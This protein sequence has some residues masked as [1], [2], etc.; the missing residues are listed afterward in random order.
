[1]GIFRNVSG[2]FM[3]LCNPGM[4]ATY[5][6]MVYL[7]PG[8]IQNPEHI[9]NSVK[10]LQSS[11]LRKI[12][13]GCN[14]FRNA[15]FSRSL[16]YEINIMNIYFF[17]HRHKKIYRCLNFCKLLRNFL[18]TFQQNICG[19]LLCK[20]TCR[21]SRKFSIKLFRAGIKF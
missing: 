21:P 12:V 13:N 3:A 7:E 6:F 8:H 14:Y 20:Y 19:R 16:L 11:V 4:L 9:Q 1:M 15:N 17:F 18:E 2:I 5:I 10:H